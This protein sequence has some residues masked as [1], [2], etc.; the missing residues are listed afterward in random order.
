MASAI[1]LPGQLLCHP[2]NM[3]LHCF[4]LGFGFGAGDARCSGG[5]EECR[6]EERR[7]NERRGL[8]RRMALSYITSGCRESNF[9]LRR[10]RQLPSWVTAAKLLASLANGQREWRK[11][12]G[13]IAGA[14]RGLSQVH[15]AA[16]RHQ[17][18]T[19]ERPWLAASRQKAA[20]GRMP[21]AAKGVGTGDKDAWRWRGTAEKV[22]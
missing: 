5:M 18:P 16:W 21:N 7:G 12:L 9:S 13:V 6:G 2:L 15:G 4:G 8:G 22:P 1:R 14:G 19:N 11:P 17:G 20:H 10:P 3:V